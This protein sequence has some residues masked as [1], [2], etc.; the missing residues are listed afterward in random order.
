[1]DKPTDECR[2]RFAEVT[3][4]L[5]TRYPGLTTGPIFGL[6]ALKIGTKPFACATGEDMV[7]KL[8]GEANERA[9]A[10]PGAKRFEPMHGRP[11]KGWVQVPPEQFAEWDDLAEQAYASLAAEL[12]LD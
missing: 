8:G 3:E 2:E 9:L 7:F 5:R 6:P 4:E 1:M 11:M 10:L 12:G